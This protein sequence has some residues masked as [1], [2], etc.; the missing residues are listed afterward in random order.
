[1]NKYTNINIINISVK[2]KMKK[3]IMKWIMFNFM[4]I[5]NIKNNYWN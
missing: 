2:V 5:N 3:N 1:M 4:I